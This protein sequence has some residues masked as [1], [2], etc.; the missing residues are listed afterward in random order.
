MD[1]ETKALL[2][3]IARSLDM[4]ALNQTSQLLA[5]VSKHGVESDDGSRILF[6]CLARVEEAREALNKIDD[7]KG[8]NP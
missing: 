5:D 7:D 3:L 1:C 2:R 8:A 6:H 4:I